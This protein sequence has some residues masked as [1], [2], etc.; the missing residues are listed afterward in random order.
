MNPQ[1]RAREEEEDET[2]FHLT[3][4]RWWPDLVCNANCGHVGRPR[5]V[6]G[7]RQVKGGCSHVPADGFA[8]LM[9]PATEADS[10]GFTWSLRL[11]GRFHFVTLVDFDLV[12]LVG[13]DFRVAA[14]L[15][16]Y[17]HVLIF[18]LINL[19]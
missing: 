13:T 16:Y 18:S 17:N 8:A 5:R 7:Q 2:H 1:K 15:K 10:H 14:E 4:F 19:P 12:R 3:H 6:L 9:C 11:V